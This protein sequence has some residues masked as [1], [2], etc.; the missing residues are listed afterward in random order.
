M[1]RLS[2]FSNSTE[3]T[4]K[5]IH[6]KKWQQCQ[7]GW[8]PFGPLCTPFGFLHFW[9]LGPLSLFFYNKFLT[10]GFWVWRESSFR[11]F[12]EEC[13]FPCW[14]L[15]VFTL[16]GVETRK[17]IEWRCGGVLWRWNCYVVFF[18]LG[19]VCYNWTQN[20]YVARELSSEVW[21]AEISRWSSRRMSTKANK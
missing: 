13:F 7:P 18:Y 4:P 20:D 21:L 2:L 14:R 12:K 11:V 15:V 19:C 17:S 9:F 5:R 16:N 8:H 3:W 10:L 6:F 1:A